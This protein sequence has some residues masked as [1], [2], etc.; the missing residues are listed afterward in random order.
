[1]T[2]TTVKKAISEAKRFLDAAEAWEDRCKEDK[3]AFLG[4][5]EGGTLRRASLDLSRALSEMRKR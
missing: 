1:M 3:L 5:K 4:S 2:A